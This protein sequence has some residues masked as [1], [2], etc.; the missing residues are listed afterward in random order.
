M[1]DFLRHFLRCEHFRLHA[2]ALLEA[3]IVDFAFPR[4]SNQN[5]L[6]LALKRERFRNAPRPTAQRLCR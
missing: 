3:V 6:L 4:R 2:E 1:A 5:R